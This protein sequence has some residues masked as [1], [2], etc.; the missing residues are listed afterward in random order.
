MK[1]AGCQK[2]LFGIESGNEKIRNQIIGKGITDEQIKQATKLCWQVGIEPDYYLMI[3]HP[4]ETMKEVLDTVNFSL[5]FKPNI[6]GVFITMPLPGSPLFDRAI[7]EVVI[8]K[9]VID[10]FING[11]Y[12][13]S[14]EGCWPYYV[15]KGLTLSQLLDAR[16]L[17]YR[18]FYFRPSYILNRIKRDCTSWVKIKRDIKES[19]SLLIRD[20]AINDFDVSR[21]S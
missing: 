7:K 21:S 13:Q 9:D 4:T 16:K 5:R 18:K 3:G 2:L 17:A 8:D 1:K 12:G 20:R 6:I 11:E 10:R 14:Y 15:P 19:F